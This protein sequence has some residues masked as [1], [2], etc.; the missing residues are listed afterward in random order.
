MADCHIAIIPHHGNEE[1]VGAGKAEEEEE[2]GGT[3]RKGDALGGREQVGQQLRD[4]DK[5]VA[6]FGKRENEQET[7]HGSVQS[8]ATADNGHDGGIGQQDGQ[9]QEK[10]DHKQQQ[11]ELPQAGEA[12]QDKLGNHRGSV[13]TMHLDDFFLQMS[14]GDTMMNIFPMTSLSVSSLQAQNIDKSFC[15]SLSL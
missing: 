13:G 8:P 4:D 14:L 3:G 10:E 12:H 5:R 2:L 9:V 1:A 7:V 6:G 15:L 11:L